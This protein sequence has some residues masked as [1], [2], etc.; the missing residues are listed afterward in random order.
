MND[1]QS[2]MQN[3]PHGIPQGSILGPLF[4]VI[5]INDLPMHIDNA[6]VDLFADDRTL[7][8]SVDYTEILQ[9]RKIMD[10]PLLVLMIGL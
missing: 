4:F 6:E 9:L 3:V 8:V 2:S 7:S 10:E 1:V 5:F